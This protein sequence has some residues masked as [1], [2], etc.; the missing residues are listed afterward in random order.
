VVGVQLGE[1]LL[2]LAR[3]A[4]QPGGPRAVRL[5]GHQL[6]LAAVDALEH[7]AE[8]PGGVAEEVVA[9][10][11]ELL[12]A[13]E[14]ERE[15]VGPGRGHEERVDA[16]GDRVVAQHPRAQVRHREHRQLAERRLQ[17][18]LDLAAQ[19]VGRRLRARDEQEILGGHP[20]VDQ[21]GEALDEDAGL[22]GARTAEDEERPLLVGHRRALGGGELVE[23]RRHRPIV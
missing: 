21:P 17:D 1:L 11:G 23:P 16:G 20:L 19:H 3:L 14:Q 2:A 8:Q 4:L 15:A 9:A 10:Q 5:G 18:V 6:E 13:V 22:A 12:H 7:R